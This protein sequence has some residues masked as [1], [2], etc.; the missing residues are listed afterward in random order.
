LEVSLEPP[1]SPSTA[2]DEKEQHAKIEE[3]PMTFSSAMK[4]STLRPKNTDDTQSTLQSTNPTQRAAASI[5]Q[6]LQQKKSSLLFGFFAT[7]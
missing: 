6:I 7:R 2:N 4:P 1:Y 3:Q 5:T